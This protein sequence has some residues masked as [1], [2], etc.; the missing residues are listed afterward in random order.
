M[1][2]KGSDFGSGSTVSHGNGRATT[3]DPGGWSV[4]HYDGSGSNDRDDGRH[5]NDGNRDDY[6]HG[7]NNFAKRRAAEEAK[8]RAEE[9]AKRLA[10]EEAKRLAEEEA[11]RLAE[12]E[13]KRIAAEEAK[14]RAAEEAKRIAAAEAKRLWDADAPRREAEIAAW[15]KEK[16]EERLKNSL[17]D[18]PRIAEIAFFMNH[19]IIAAEIGGFK[20]GATNITTN[21]IRFSTQGRGAYQLKPEFEEAV[22]GEGSQTNAFRHAT[23]MSTVTARYGIEVAHYIGNAHESIASRGDAKNFKHID[24]NQRSF[25]GYDALLKA[26]SIVDM[27]NNQIGRKIG[28]ES[29]T[30][31]MK[32]LSLNALEHF[33]KEGLYVFTDGEYVQ[34]AGYYGITIGKERITDEQYN[35]MHDLFKQLDENGNPPDGYTFN[36]EGKLVPIK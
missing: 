6:N 8:R 9:E 7:D 23:W 4:N 32:Q 35:Y 2:I 30:K 18:L 15:F 34:K 22:D 13:A 28:L 26:D 20:R 11:K 33:H 14:R 3:T 1:S 16:E 12:E 17:P 29:G 25:V 36:E 27:L 24:L 31:S 5:K 19:P 10:E 21:A